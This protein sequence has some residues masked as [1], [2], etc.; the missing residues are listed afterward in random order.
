MELFGA[1]IGH[2]FSHG[3]DDKGSM[4]DGDGN[5]NQWWTAEDRKKFDNKG[6]KLATNTQPM[7]RF[8]DIR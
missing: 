4:Y 1:V 3:F 6:A 8:L 2:E 5:L 7:N